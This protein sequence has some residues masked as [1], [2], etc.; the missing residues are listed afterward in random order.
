VKIAILDQ[1]WSG[2]KGYLHIPGVVRS[3]AT[4]KEKIFI[5]YSTAENLQWNL[6]FDINPIEVAI[7]KEVGDDMC[8]FNETYNNSSQ[9]PREVWKIVS[10]CGD[11]H[12][13]IDL[14][15]TRYPYLYKII[16]VINWPN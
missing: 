13:I 16:S 6:R 14:T 11:S 1:T 7:Y 5:L 2:I 8:P 4:L 9:L 15:D 3:I 10:Y 12:N